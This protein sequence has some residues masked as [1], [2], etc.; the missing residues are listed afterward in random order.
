[1]NYFANIDLRDAAQ[2]EA[3]YDQFLD[4]LEAGCFKAAAEPAPRYEQQWYDIAS[5]LVQHSLSLPFNTCEGSKE[6]FYYGGP[7]L[8][9]ALDV[10]ADDLPK[11]PGVHRRQDFLSPE[12]QHHIH[13]QTC[14]EWFSGIGQ[15][16][17]TSL[18][19]PEQQGRI[20][21]FIDALKEHQATVSY[22][23]LTLDD[24]LLYLIM[25]ATEQSLL[26]QQLIEQ[27][28]LPTTQTPLAPYLNSC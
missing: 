17:D 5:T 10:F 13:L 16:T 8:L 6:S 24:L 14:L 7:T 15:D 28:K 25:P 19:Q 22:L 23:E 18:H 21:A 20:E 12:L 9:E 3:C 1:M 11:P 4:D 26:T 2:L 27:L